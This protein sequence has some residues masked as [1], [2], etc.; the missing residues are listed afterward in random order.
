[1]SLMVR[2]PVL[3]VMMIS[4][5]VSS[6]PYNSNTT[7]RSASLST[8]LVLYRDFH[9]NRIGRDSGEHAGSLLH[10]LTNDPLPENLVIPP[11]ISDD[12]DTSPD[13]LQTCHQFPPLIHET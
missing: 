6:L 11:I 8:L 9:V 12:D 7:V 10:R 3:S 2:V 4:L 13:V 5:V 1:M